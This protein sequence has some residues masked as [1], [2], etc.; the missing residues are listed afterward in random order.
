MGNRKKSNIMK[1][2][3]LMGALVGLV[4]VN[5]DIVPSKLR[6]FEHEGVN[7]SRVHEQMYKHKS[8]AEPYMAKARAT[9]AY[10]NPGK[11]DRL[12]EGNGEIDVNALAD[13]AID[14]ATA[15]ATAAA[16]EAADQVADA[17]AAKQA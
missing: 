17:L 5:A 8:R 6:W 4:Q 2:A 13:D 14:D 11:E 7:V 10:F 16:N 12:G 9:S 15:V 1:K 3:M